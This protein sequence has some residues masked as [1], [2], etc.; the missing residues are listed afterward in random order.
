MFLHKFAQ[1]DIQ[2]PDCM[3]FHSDVIT[4]KYMMFVKVMNHCRMKV[5]RIDKSVIT[6]HQWTT[7]EASSY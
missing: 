4:H 6:M 3:M 5:I 7:N 1:S 2:L